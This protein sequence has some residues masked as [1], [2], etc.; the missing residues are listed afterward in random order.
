MHE[1]ELKFQVPPDRRRS[2]DAAVAGR[3]AA[4]R[5]RLQ[6]AY[7]DTASRALARA[8][9]ALRI[10]REGRRWVQTLKGLGDDGITRAEHNVVLTASHQADWPADPARHAGTAVGERLA[11]VLHEAG[12]PLSLVFRTDIL[13]RTRRVRTPRGTVELAFDDGHINAGG[14]RLAVCELEIELVSGSPLAVIE[15]ARRWVL[16]HGLW[17]DTR[18]KAERGEIGRAS[19]RERV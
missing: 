18:S 12:E 15:T 13:R 16:P 11:A 5:T 2:V 9:L 17:L 1:I 10:R 8:G 4:P 3:A 7:F 6:A 19:C 14:Q